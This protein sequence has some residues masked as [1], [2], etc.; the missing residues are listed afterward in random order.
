MTDL[1]RSLAVI[2]AA[3]PPSTSCTAIASMSRRE[4]RLGAPT[5]ELWTLALWATTAA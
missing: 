2:G 5:N 3:R 1:N 4:R